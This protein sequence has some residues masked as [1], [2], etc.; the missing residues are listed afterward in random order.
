MTEPWKTEDW[1]VSPWNFLPEITQGMNFQGN[2]KIHDTTLRDGEQ[3]AGVI[4]NKEDKLRIATM[5]DEAG[6]YRIEAGM[7]AVSP[8]DAEAIKEIANLG[9]KAEIFA[10]SRCMAEDVNRAAEAGVSGIVMEV[11]SSG[12]L[13]ENG[14]KWPLERAIETSIKA[15]L[16]AKEAGLYTVFFPIDASRA[17]MTWYLNL[18]ET[19]ATEGHMDALALVDTFGVLSPE[20]VRYFV[21]RT[22][23]RINVPLETH[24]HMD[25]GL[26]VANTIAALMDGVEIAQT[27]VTGLGERAGNTPMEDLVMSLQTMYGVGSGIRTESLYPLSREV[28]KRAGHRV[29]QNRQI[30]GDNLFEVESGII[31]T[32]FRNLGEEQM[33][34]MYPFLAR[35]VGQE[36][37]R[38]VLGKGSGLDSIGIWMDR[39]GVKATDEEMLEILQ[40]VKQYSLERK[41]TLTE[42]EFRLICDQSLSKIED[43][44]QP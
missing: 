41:R 34:L 40:Q 43:K 24:F 13:I 44:E 20:A 36:D 16:A 3:Q 26:G 27:T 22:R 37:P 29:P 30:V 31:T 32:W 23:D 14:Y 1:F 39:V 19:I 2:V 5:L 4:F 9:L 35:M 11:P 12:H 8:A 7:P 33:T 18:I 28:T 17:D 38:T 10:F 6:V 15:T 25:F 21:R 42:D